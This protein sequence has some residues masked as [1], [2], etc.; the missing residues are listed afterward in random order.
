[1]VRGCEG[2]KGGD[3]APGRLP[4]KAGQGYRQG[5]HTGNTIVSTPEP[6]SLVQHPFPLGRRVMLELPSPAV[7]R[8]TALDTRP[9]AEIGS[10]A[11]RRS[12]ADA[13][14]PRRQAKRPCLPPAP[15]WAEL[16]PPGFCSV[17]S[18]ARKQTLWGCFF[19]L[20]FL[21]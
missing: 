16:P 5:W 18:S 8:D 10:R 4:K 15:V 2:S 14:C 12:P 19:F 9:Q 11:G 7:T 20:P 1:M 3:T 13:R 6:S 21:I 17:F